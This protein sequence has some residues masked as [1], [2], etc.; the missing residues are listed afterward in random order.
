MSRTKTNQKKA[1]SIFTSL[2]LAIS[3]VLL[4]IPNLSVFAVGNVQ[5]QTIEWNVHNGGQTKTITVS[6]LAKSYEVH[7]NSTMLRISTKNYRTYTIQIT[8][9]PYSQ[10]RKATIDFYATPK[11]A[12]RPNEKPLCKYIITQEGKR[13]KAELKW[14]N[15]NTVFSFLPK[16]SHSF[17][18]ILFT[19]KSNCPFKPL[20]VD[21]LPASAT[22]YI[23]R[24]ISNDK[25]QKELFTV[26][27]NI[28][29]D[30][31]ILTPGSNGF[32]GTS[33]TEMKE[34]TIS[35]NI[36]REHSKMTVAE[37]AYDENGNLIAKAYSGDETK[38][39]MMLRVY[40]TSIG[41][42]FNVS[43]PIQM[44]NLVHYKEEKHQKP[45][46][47]K[48]AIPPCQPYS[49]ERF[50]NRNKLNNN[51][52]VKIQKTANGIFTKLEEGQGSLPIN[53]NNND[54]Y[55]YWE[56]NTHG[57]LVAG[58]SF[59]QAAEDFAIVAEFDLKPSGRDDLDMQIYPLLNKTVNEQGQNV[60]V[61]KRRTFGIA[62][63]SN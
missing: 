21:S 6:S 57:Y 31:N 56:C 59:K 27:Q 15:A 35:M 2:I 54:L 53:T 25:E 50:P 29:G 16:D 17:Q 7:G 45:A 46:E 52:W 62:S 43:V 32:Y 20:S 23:F 18:I 33:Q 63:F 1:F 48:T 44:E 49:S 22:P 12:R 42:Q 13:I 38:A 19:I 3:F 51:E 36:T 61:Y 28:N 14:N 8:N 47:F 60:T 30:T 40:F 26:T 11:I 55:L 24:K 9:N 37:E 39:G 34:Y 41:E 5:T 4:C 58:C 10:S